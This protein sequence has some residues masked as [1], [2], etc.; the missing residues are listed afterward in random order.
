MVHSEWTGVALVLV[1]LS[2]V[3]V[4]CADE[5][6]SR[7]PTH[8]EGFDLTV[9]APESYRG[10][11]TP[12]VLEQFYA[13]PWGQRAF[14]RAGLFAQP[15][16]FVLTVNWNRA[17]QEL[18]RSTLQ[19]PEVLHR[20]N[21]GYITVL[22]NADLRPDIRERYQTG[23]W[24][25]VAFLLPDGAPMLS[26][27]NDRGVAKPITTS[28]VDRESLLF[29]LR[30]A[31]VY[32]SRQREALLEGGARWAA[33]EGPDPPEPG[34]VQAPASEVMARWLLGNAD[35]EQGGFG[36]GAKFL[37]PALDEYAG[38]REARG[39][40]ALR[41]HSRLTLETLVSS[42]LFDRVEGGLHRLATA[43]DFGKIQYEKMLTGNAQLLRELVG[44]LRRADSA[45]LRQALK[46]T[47]RFMIG[48]LGR[49]G[50]GFYLAQA[51]DPDSDDGGG[52]WRRGG[53][54][55]PPP[56]DRLVLSAP[57]AIAGAAMVRAG[58]LLDSTELIARGRSALDLVHERAFV[59]G[60]G[61]AHAIEPVR[62]S[63]VYLATLADVALAFLDAY[64]T[65]GQP[66]DLTA[67]RDILEFARLNLKDPK[68]RI[69]RDHLPGPS[70]LGLLVNERRPLRPNVRLARGMLRLALH[71]QGQL[72][73]DEAVAILAS[74]TGD[75]SL[76]GVHGIEAGLAVEE[77]IAEPLRIRIAGPLDSVGAIALRR[78][79]ANAA[80]PWTLVETG[81]AEA[82]P[83]ATLS[84][85][86]LTRQVGDPELLPQ[87]IRE[88]VGGGS[89]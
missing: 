31:A 11:P 71:G 51:A 21:Q 25:V 44:S 6:A 27:V 58:L 50:S 1:A 35:R 14:R 47:A 28:A 68:D 89:S 80:W 32:W 5:P 33:E 41:E 87:A 52:Y 66:R 46:K 81:S 17:G 37:L 49:E 75:L 88:L 77:T 18:A 72:Y 61:V 84:F 55:D 82:A 56:V 42:P 74:F 26:R 9:P 20:L 29:L 10:W 4:L 63:G 43:P 57:N 36:A 13:I 70:P 7:A 85:G 23:G 69:Y 64:E 83:Q 15:V 24:P 2:S 62:T 76:Y 59:P 79:A 39:L 19:D 34:A 48:T 40:P 86:G 53:K 65:T 38:V 16:F 67:A 60:R 3:G 12:E 45:E 54:G 73:R 22:V 8:L 78:A 30:E